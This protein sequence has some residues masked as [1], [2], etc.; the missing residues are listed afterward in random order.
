MDMEQL[1]DKIRGKKIDNF[2]NRLHKKIHKQWKNI[3]ALHCENID[4]QQILI[5]LYDPSSQI[6]QTN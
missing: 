3:Y 5:R 2:L 4:P 1:L 6:L